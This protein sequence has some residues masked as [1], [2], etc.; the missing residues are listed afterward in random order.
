MKNPEQM[1]SDVFPRLGMA[2]PSAA[3]IYLLT[4]KSSQFFL[5][6]LKCHYYIPLWNDHRGW[7]GEGG[8]LTPVINLSQTT[9]SKRA[10]DLWANKSREPQPG[11]EKIMRL[12]WLSTCQNQRRR[13]ERWHKK[14]GPPC[15]WIILIA[16]KPDFKSI[17][18]LFFP[19]LKKLNK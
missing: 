5:W 13:R 10:Q 16:I 17:L 7:A 14:M 8:D 9:S 19:P 4:S 6:L 12:G 2:F 11:T 3:I 1:P 15:R 18:Q